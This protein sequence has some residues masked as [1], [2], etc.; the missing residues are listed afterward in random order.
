MLPTV[1][2]RAGVNR[3]SMPRLTP[4]PPA[5]APPQL[6][7]PAAT[8]P[9]T[10]LCALPSFPEP[11]QS[12]EI[13]PDPVPRSATHPETD[14]SST[15]ESSPSCRRQDPSADLHAARQ[16]PQTRANRKD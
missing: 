7:S 6:Q 8:V 9:E 1:P 2:L 16:N 13:I 4:S 12:C 10:V 15:P 5:S 3:L 14:P 11:G